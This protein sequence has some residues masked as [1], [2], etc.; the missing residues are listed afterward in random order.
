MNEAAREQ[1]LENKE[2]LCA[3][4]QQAPRLLV[5]SVVPTR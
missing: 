2:D 4:Q 5:E 3:Q 1:K